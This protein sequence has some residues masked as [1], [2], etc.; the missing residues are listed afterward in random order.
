[1]KLSIDKILSV[2]L[3]ISLPFIL[4][5]RADCVQHEK[6]EHAGIGAVRESQGA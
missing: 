2:I 1:M 3:T 4:L 6:N 5:M